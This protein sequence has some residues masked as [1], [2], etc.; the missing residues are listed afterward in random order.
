MVGLRREKSFGGMQG[1][2]SRKAQVG[3]LEVLERHTE[4]GDSIS[5]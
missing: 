1:W 3:A 4:V 5:E 2:G